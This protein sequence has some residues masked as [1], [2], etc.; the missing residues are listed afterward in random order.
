MFFRR[1]RGEFES[2]ADEVPINAAGDKG[3]VVV[4]QSPALMIDPTVLEEEWNRGI[5]ATTRLYEEY[6]N[7]ASKSGPGTPQLKLVNSF[8]NESLQGGY[9]RHRSRHHENNGYEPYYVTETG[10]TFVLAPD[11]STPEGIAAGKS[12]IIAWLNGGLPLPTWAAKRYGTSFL[13]NPFLPRDGFA[14]IAVN[15]PAQLKLAVK[16]EEVRR[17]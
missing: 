13:E 14:E 9:L 4:L 12:C 11:H 6:F 15:V 7:E 3:W 16:E 10:S 17:L 5:D 8:R 1:K 2:S